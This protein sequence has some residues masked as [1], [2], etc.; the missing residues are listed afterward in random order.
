MLKTQSG[1]IAL[2]LLLVIVVA[3]AA[4]LG[5][6]YLGT[7]TTAKPGS[8]DLPISSPM[9]ISEA[10]TAPVQTS[11][12]PE[13]WVYQKSESCAVQIPIPPQ[14]EPYTTTSFP[15]GGAADDNNRYWRFLENT[16]SEMLMFKDDALAIYSPVTPSEF[17]NDYNPGSVL[18]FCTQNPSN[19]NPDQIISQ[20][21]EFIK[22][23]QW[24]LKVLD[25]GA[26]NKWGFNT[27]KIKMEGGMF[28]D[29]LIY[30]FPANGKMYFVYSSSASPNQP[31]KDTTKQ[32]FDN[33]KFAN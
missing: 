16:D 14:A 8:P 18:V 30:V 9:A 26:E 4:S 28:G 27:R 17:G 20:I 31:V 3:A 15:P 7:K 33:L 25:Q 32:I 1:N 11:S 22:T 21:N 29:T 12:L 23:Q 13:G 5:G 10:S 6:Y 19:L 2:V 24:D